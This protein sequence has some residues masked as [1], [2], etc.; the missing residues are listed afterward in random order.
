MED[1]QSSEVK[2]SS[3]NGLGEKRERKILMGVLTGLCVVALIL[4]VI[5]IAKNF[6]S[7]KNDTTA[8]TQT[9]S[10]EKISINDFIYSIQREVNEAGSIEGGI[11]IFESAIAEYKNDAE[12]TPAL[13][14][15]YAYFLVSHD[16]QDDGFSQLNS[17]DQT[18]LAPKQLVKLN[19]AYRDYY[20]FIGEKEESE[21]Y[22]LEI[23]RLMKE[24]NFDEYTE[25]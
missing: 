24:N 17:I 20:A 23:E 3:E 5:I 1:G 9:V 16:R 10:E 21:N 18:S 13:R 14:I 12:K 15:A 2:R 7:A 25:F 8:E 6:N 22:V 19:M 4:G 11:E